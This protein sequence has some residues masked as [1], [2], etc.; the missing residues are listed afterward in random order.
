MM[1]RGALGPTRLV[2]IGLA[3]LALSACASMPASIEPTRNPMH[4]PAPDWDPAGPPRIANSRAHLQ[5]VPYAREISGIEIYGDAVTWWNQAAGRYPRSGT[6]A[7]GSVLVV[8]GY[9][10]P[11]RGHV[12]VVRNV[13]SS[14]IITIDHANWHNG[15]EI[16]VAVPVM[17]VSAEGDWSAV[18]V[19]YIP[20]RHWGGRIY[21]PQGFIHPF[22]LRG[23]SS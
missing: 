22:S 8:Q 9:N 1:M 21:R 11:R 7:S 12:A 2:G 15:G 18:R 19:W 5:C 3:A 23:L 10:N 13:L 14:R 4:L 17:D 20:G 6:P 16:S